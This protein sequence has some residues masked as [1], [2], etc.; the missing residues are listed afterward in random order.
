MQERQY[1]WGTFLWSKRLPIQK[2]L[3]QQDSLHQVTC[4][5]ASF[6]SKQQTCSTVRPLWCEPLRQLLSLIYHMPETC[7]YDDML[8]VLHLQII[9]S[10]S[11]NVTTYPELLSPNHPNLNINIHLFSLAKSGVA[12]KKTLW[13]KSRRVSNHKF[14]CKHPNILC[15]HHVMMQFSTQ[16][17]VSSWTPKLLLNIQWNFPDE[18]ISTWAKGQL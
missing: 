3:Y 1:H 9:L 2:F 7:L 10:N 17:A 14:N 13:T 6:K 18:A 5:V 16:L 15:W 8:D 4:I 11:L 12:S